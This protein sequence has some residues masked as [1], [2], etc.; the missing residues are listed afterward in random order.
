MY[1]L[2]QFKQKMLNEKKLIRSYF[3]EIYNLIPFCQV[4]PCQAAQCPAGPE[5]SLLSHWYKQTAK[6]SHHGAD[7]AAIIRKEIW[8]V[9]SSGTAF[10]IHWRVSNIC[11]LQ[12]AAD[13]GT[14]DLEE[15]VIDLKGKAGRSR[16][17]SSLGAG[18]ALPHIQRIRSG[19]QLGGGQMMSR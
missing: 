11:T 16:R 15:V 14:E 5:V 18:S 3:N 7:P 10:I 4:E 1:Y 12:H 19:G 6:R 17:S 9:T 2:S 8:N 13:D